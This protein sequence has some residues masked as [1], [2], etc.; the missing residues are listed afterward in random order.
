MMTF[1]IGKQF[2]NEAELNTWL[3]DNLQPHPDGSRRTYQGKPV[4]AINLEQAVSANMKRG[5]ITLQSIDTWN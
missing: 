3:E 1:E 5:P 2:D 4:W